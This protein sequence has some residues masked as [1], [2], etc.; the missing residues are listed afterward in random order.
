[1]PALEIFGFIG[2]NKGVF[3]P[4]FLAFSCLAGAQYGLGA[5]APSYFIRVHD[6]TQLEVGQLFGPVLMIAGPLGVISGGFAAERMLAR[7]VSD[8]TLRLPMIAV[9]AAIPFAIAFPLVDSPM[10]AL[11]LLG[12]VTFLGTIPFG[13]GVATFPLI[14]PNRMRAQVMAVYLLIA[15]LLSYSLGPTL[16]ALITDH[17]FAD[18][19]A[20]NLSLAIAVPSVMVAGA[21]L[22]LFAIR[23]YRVMVSAQSHGE[24]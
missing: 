13:A 19:K 9:L 3:L 22:I 18:E 24:T 16:I 6:W 10:M 23:P 5:W 20:I 17:V 2:G 1:A 12:L 15:N 8:A 7:G 14:T 4:L 11:G 21:L